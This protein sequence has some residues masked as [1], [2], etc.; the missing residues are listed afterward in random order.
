V[1]GVLRDVRFMVR[2][3]SRTPGLA[4]AIALSLALG[5][6]SNTAVFSLMR[7]LLLKALP[8]AAPDEL[9]LLYWG[10]D[11][12][13]A[14]L[15]KSSGSSPRE[16]RWRTSN[17]TFAYPFYTQLTGRSDILSSVFAFAPLGSR[18]QNTTFVADGAADP[19]DGEMVSGTYF[20]GL[21]VAAAAGRTINADDEAS[22]A[23]VAVI[24]YR[25]WTRRFGGDQ[26][27]LGRAVT[28]NNVPFAIVG[29]AP[30]GFFGVEP[31]RAPDVWVPMLDLPELTPWGY[32]PDGTPSVMRSRDYWWVHVMARLKPGVEAHQAEA[33]LGADLEAFAADALPAMNRRDPPRVA[34]ESAS[35]GLDTMRST[36]EGPLRM[37]LAIAAIVLIIACANVAL[38]LLS[39]ATAR[40]RE[41]ALR[42]SLGASP[43]RV[44]RQVLTESLLMALV[45]TAFGVLWAAWTSRALLLLVPA[46]RRPL[47]D[48]T[49]DGG[50]LLFAAAV[51]GLTA[52]AFGLAPALQAGRVDVLSALR[53]GSGT[54]AT[55]G[56]GQRALSSA[57]VVVQIA[58]SLVLLAGTALFLRTLSNLRHE[59]LGL[60]QGRVLVFSVDASQNGYAGDRLV[61]IY[62]ALIRGLQQEPGVEAA[63]AARLRLFSGAISLAP[64]TPDNAAGRPGSGVQ[65]NAV[66]PDFARTLGMRLL[67]GRDLT[68]PD[69]DGH[70]RVALLSE[71]AARR[72][73]GDTRAVGRRFN[74]G[75]GV[76][77]T[78]QYEVVGVV[79]NSKYGRVRGD[80]PPVAYVPYTA[81][82][83]A[84]QALSLQVRTAAPDPL[85]LAAS[86]RRAIERVDPRLAVQEFDSMRNHIEDSLWQER[87]F[88]RLTAAFAAVSV[89]LA[90]LGV[91]GTVSYA[92][93]RRRSEIALRIALG[94]RRAQVI[95]V[96][97]KRALLL[98]AV[99]SAIGL[100]LALWA[101]R[102]IA[103]WL[104]GL[105]HSDAATLAGSTLLL[106]AIAAAASY[107]PARRAT[108]V[109]PSSA[110]KQE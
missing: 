75:S 20:G 43:Q 3:V 40:R 39:R 59:P 71:A 103:T 33:A 97:L 104:Y 16:A 54:T 102:F 6:G 83:G 107:L 64:L 47:L 61:A 94:A 53:S 79:A 42:L 91:Y 44:I 12:F 24:S 36:Y 80:F 96:V 108:L 37:L 19:V 69:V 67:D 8:V 74:L 62:G 34:F 70:R 21:G 23:R 15:R 90:C 14:G 9:V 68:W 49:I 13:P 73:Y 10:S 27:V 35:A 99:G 106:V 31:G 55:E 86:V 98:A 89:L 95:A 76:D 60:D 92:V 28:V 5:I 17:R 50:A 45:G 56:R 87:L 82:Q 52:L 30:R 4:V 22:G 11:T 1:N 38:L 25:Y 18:R 110:L 109:A 48:S 2:N 77:P 85:A 101:G 66:G 29:V 57:F 65:W 51:G 32:R 41:F 100:A 78:T 26:G 88:A 7:T 105:S 93:R 84:L 46:A 63:T 72:F 58:L 81:A